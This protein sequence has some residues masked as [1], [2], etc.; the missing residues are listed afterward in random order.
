MSIS[1]PY[2]LHVLLW[3]PNSLKFTASLS[4]PPAPPPSFYVVETN[5]LQILF[6]LIE[7]YIYLG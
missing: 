6:R 2:L 3:T 1:L 7:V 5:N 4:S